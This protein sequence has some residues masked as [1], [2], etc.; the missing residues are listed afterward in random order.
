MPAGRGLPPALPSCGSWSHGRARGL[1]TDGGSQQHRSARDPASTNHK[2]TSYTAFNTHGVSHI[3]GAQRV[4]AGALGGDSDL[5]GP[6]GGGGVP[7]AQEGTCLGFQEHESLEGAAQHRG[8]RPR[9]EVLG[10][11]CHQQRKVVPRGQGPEQRL[12]VDRGPSTGS[13]TRGGAAHV[14]G[15]R[16]GPGG[17]DMPYPQTVMGRGPTQGVKASDSL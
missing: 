7:Q 1:R 5:G 17:S 9:T 4:R 12:D 3:P 15:G 13:E 10:P 8:V 2:T 6:L 11:E 14:V 16:G